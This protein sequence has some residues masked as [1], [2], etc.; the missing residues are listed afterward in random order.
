MLSAILIDDERHCCETLR[1]LLEKHPQRVRVEA[2]FQ[3]PKKALAHLRE[4]RPDVLFL[5]IEMPGMNGFQLLE[6]LDGAHGQVIFTTAYD[7]FAVKAFKV[8]AID[9]LLKPIQED[10]LLAAL[11]KVEAQRGNG[12]HALPALEERMRQLMQDLQA[13]VRKGQRIA[14]STV[15]GLDLVEADDI[16]CCQSESNYTRIHLTGERR[17]LV[18]KTLREVEEQLPADRFLR[19]HHSYVAHMDHVQKYLRGDGG[20]LVMDNG[21]EVKVSRNRKEEVVERLGG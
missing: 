5:D 3:D 17:I 2:V 19:V 11:E 7:R 21:M 1:Y 18:S 9:Y 6:Q 20:T 10:E 14:F 4:H 12:D 8:N 13:P 15:H 16:I